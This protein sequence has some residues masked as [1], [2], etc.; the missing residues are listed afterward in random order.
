MV[1][2]HG[3]WTIQETT[4][5]YFDSFIDVC[6]DQVLRP[7]GQPGTYATV[8][9][10][11]A[12]AVL[13]IDRDNVVY[14]TRQFRYAIGK[15]SVEVVCGNV[16]KNEPPLEAAKREV[17]EEVGIEANELMELG[18]IDL[19]TSLIYCKL[20]L[21]VAKCL[22][23]TSPQREETETI[24]T[25]KMP[26]DEAVQMVMESAITHG[27]SCVLILKARNAMLAG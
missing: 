1:R 7:N 27:P 12:V 6:E 17:R 23:F 25:V 24:E 19:D 21:F 14:L 9:M 13:P 15:E 5:K 8:T 2:K 18:V 16:D 11:P 22:T 4:Q 26:F 10:K 3:P 20:H